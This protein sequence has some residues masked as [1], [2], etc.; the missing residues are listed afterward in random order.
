[1]GLMGLAP[2]LVPFDRPTTSV[3]IW[4]ELVVPTIA[5]VLGPQTRPLASEINGF[6]Q[7]TRGCLPGTNQSLWADGSSRA[8]IGFCISFIQRPTDLVPVN[9]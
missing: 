8:A 7:L 5:P 3:G 9:L 1:M 6:G 2:P 4:T